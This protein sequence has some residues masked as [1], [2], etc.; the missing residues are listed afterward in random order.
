M[1]DILYPICSTVKEE[2]LVSTEEH[3]LK[4]KGN[5]LGGMFRSFLKTTAK[6]VGKRMLDTGLEMGRQLVQDVTNSQPLKKAAKT[7][8]K[9]AGKHLLTQVVDD[10]TQQGRGKRIY[11]RGYVKAAQ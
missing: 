7:R 11:K 10:I 5:G 3:T 1:D 2:I 4:F 8:A 9:A 6:K